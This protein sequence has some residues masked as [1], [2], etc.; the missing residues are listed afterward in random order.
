M[1]PMLSTLAK[2]PFPSYTGSSACTSSGARPGSGACPGPGTRSG[3]STRSGSGACPG[4]STRSGS[5]YTDSRAGSGTDAG[6]T[7][8][9]PSSYSCADTPNADPYSRTDTSSANPYL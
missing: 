7:C 4:P 5:T 6:S 8:A 1:F 9:Y 3:S 2:R